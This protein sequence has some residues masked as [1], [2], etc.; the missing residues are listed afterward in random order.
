MTAIKVKLIFHTKEVTK[1]IDDA[2]SKRMAEAVIAVQK[3][4][5]EETLIG[6]RSGRTYLVP[7]TKRTYTASSPGQPPAS[8]SGHLRQ[9]IETSVEG[10]GR[11]VIG[12]VGT[13]VPYGKM[14]EFGTKGGTVIRAK[15]KA[16]A[17]YAGGAMVFVKQVIQGPI[18]PR[19]WLK[20]SF[21]KAEGKVKEILGGGKWFL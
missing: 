8:P 1:S 4:V 18:K 2:A 3:T 6:S 10:D 9:H 7:G 14:L 11:K 5:V 17:F 21:E 16:L 12:R 13:D 20:P 15:G 19:P